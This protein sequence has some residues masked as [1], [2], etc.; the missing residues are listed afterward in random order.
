MAESRKENLL[1]TALGGGLL[2][3]LGLVTISQWENQSHRADLE[4]FTEDTAA[5]DTQ[6]FPAPKDF[7]D[8]QVLVKW[9]G[10]PLYHVGKGL[11]EEHDSQMIKVGLEDSGHY[12][13][14]RF[15]NE[16]S[17]HPPVRYYLKAGFEQFVPVQVK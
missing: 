8:D 3:L 9:H 10:K 6:F 2:L 5:G 7:R 15:R 17:E 4:K 11:S 13:L 12:E 14:Y 1:L 16:K